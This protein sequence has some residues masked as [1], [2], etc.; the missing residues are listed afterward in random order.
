MDLFLRLSVPLFLFTATGA[1]LFDLMPKTRREFADWVDR[2]F[3]CLIL[4]LSFYPIFFLVAQGLLGL[5]VT[6]GAVLGVFLGLV[7]AR[8]AL[9]ELRRRRKP[10]SSR[11][12]WDDELITLPK[13][14]NE[15]MINLAIF[16]ALGTL[17][18]FALNV[19]LL[20]TL[21]FPGKLLNA[22]PFRHH[23]R[24]EWVIQTGQIA[25]WDPYI[26]GQVPIYELQGC[27][28]L[29]AIIS[30]ISGF[31][32]HD[33]WRWG[34]PVL[35]AL[36]AVTVYL[37]AKYTLRDFT[38]LD[39]GKKRSRTGHPEF[40]FFQKDWGPTLVGLTSAGFLAASPI[41]ILRTNI[42]F[43]E[44]FALPFFAPALLFYLFFMQD[45]EVEYAV[46]FGL[47]FTALSINNPIPA[48]YLVPLFVGH[49]AYHFLKTKDLRIVYGHC[50]AAGIFFLTLFVWSRSFL[51]VPLSVGAWA[52]SRAGTEGLM[53][54]VQT[55]SGFLGRLKDCFQQFFAE[56]GKN[57]S[58]LQLVL[59]GVGSVIIL[60]R[61]GGWRLDVTNSFY[62][63]F[64]F[65]YLSLIFF[66]P[67]GIPSF[68]SKYY[69]NFLP[70]SYAFAILSAY[71][72]YD[73]ALT[74]FENKAL[75]TLLF[76]A[77]F[78]G[79]LRYAAYGKT[80][81]EWVLN[82]SEEE[83]QAAEWIEKNAGKNSVLIGNWYTNDFMR[84][85]TQRRVLYAFE[86]RPIVKYGMDRVK[87]DIPV[88]KPDPEA[89]LAYVDRHPGDYYLMTSLWGPPGVYGENSRFEKS[90]EFGEG[91]R[92]AVKIFRIRAR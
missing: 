81:G 80:W 64:Y 87:L 56:V 63:L 6:R 59:G 51:G 85:L 29:A 3:L 50:T 86:A 83:F 7:L 27:Y 88:L 65:L 61:K 73:L 18:Y 47:L 15:W 1:L 75:R 44:A 62:L 32:A 21:E 72:L 13:S 58:W 20:N 91:K 66:I 38:R 84:S 28:I 53:S 48:V 43:S 52:N 68:T 57:L 42:G 9:G 41:H 71:L 14:L 69:R 33:L 26:V 49:S 19:R 23:I 5:P 10:G 39:P 45:P 70:A 11:G 25:K 40:H 37:L 36:S 82:C 76:S 8:A 89:V 46:L 55:H 30:L 78:L 60:R 12:A 35:G 67:L 16:A 34:A 17:F 22:D 54:A 4:G 31:S 90:A 92:T 24:T 79:S 74:I 77:F 2:A